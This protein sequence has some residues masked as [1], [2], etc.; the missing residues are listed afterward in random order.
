MA[1]IIDSLDYK[2]KRLV[3]ANKIDPMVSFYK[4][5]SGIRSLRFNA[6]LSRQV[7]DEQRKCRLVLDGSNI[8]IFFGDDGP[9]NLT[10]GVR[11][12]RT[13]NRQ[14]WLGRDLSDALSQY[15]GEGRYHAEYNEANNCVVIKIKE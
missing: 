6:A 7:G 14:L 13:D 3:R 2:T 1:I 10:L 15:V 5:S 9:R 11:Y 8:I 12:K 4:H